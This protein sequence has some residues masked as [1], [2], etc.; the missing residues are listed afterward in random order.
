M[1]FVQ[2]RNKFGEFLFKIVDSCFGAINALFEEFDFVVFLIVFCGL[3]F[4]IFEL[5]QDFLAI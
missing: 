5:T 2:G 3:L 4:D 1:S